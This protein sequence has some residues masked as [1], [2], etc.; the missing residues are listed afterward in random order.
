MYVRGELYCSAS[1]LFVAEAGPFSGKPFRVSVVTYGDAT[2]ERN[3]Y[4]VDGRAV[5][6]RVDTPINASTGAYF[7]GKAHRARKVARGNTHG[8]N[9]AKILCVFPRW[10]LPKLLGVWRIGTVRHAWQRPNCLV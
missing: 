9:I 10:E 3:G 4:T 8:A 1:L 6:R 7:V 5:P 2:R